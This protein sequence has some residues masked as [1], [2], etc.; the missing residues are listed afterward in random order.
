M[1]SWTFCLPKEYTMTNQLSQSHDHD[2]GDIFMPG[3]GESLA[4]PFFELS[5][6]MVVAIDSAQDN[7]LVWKAQDAPNG[8]WGETWTPISKEAYQVLATGSTV[9]GRVAIV[10]ETSGSAEIHYIDEAIENP[11]GEA[12]W[13]PPVNLGLPDGVAGMVR[14]VMARDAG[15][16]IEVFGVDGQTGGVWWIF[17]NPPKIV[18]KTEEVIPPG[19]TEPITVHAMVQEPPDQPWSVWQKLNGVEAGDL[20]LANNADGRI[21]LVAT[22]LQPANKQVHVTQQKSAKALSP[23]DWTGWERVDTPSSGQTNSQPV[24]ALD[25]EG[26][27]NIFMVGAHT[28]AV[29]LRQAKPG[30]LTWATWISPGMTGS[31]LA[32]LACGLQGNGNLIL[33]AVDVNEVLHTN[34]Q[35]SALTQHWS[36]W[37]RS[38]VAPGFGILATDYNAD[39]VLSF[40]TTNTKDDSLHMLTQADLDSTCWDAGFTRLAAGGMFTY[41]VVRDLTPPAV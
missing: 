17:Q 15:G 27:V 19:Q 16:R 26:V 24:V 3:E 38:A 11:P 4:A 8:V 25:P 36:G 32:N 6:L 28:Q 1:L 14:L 40:F 37:R 10:A 23:S 33:F 34:Y 30:S 20:S 7:K 13:N 18:E 12:R 22:T 35:P 9:D 31:P 2:D 21:V 5:R 29:Q 39:G 41:G